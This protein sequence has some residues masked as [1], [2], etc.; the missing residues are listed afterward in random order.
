[1]AFSSGQRSYLLIFCG[2][3]DAVARFHS[4]RSSSSH[5][6]QIIGTTVSNLLLVRNAL[7]DHQHRW[8][9]STSTNEREVSRLEYPSG[10]RTLTRPKT[11][12]TIVQCC[13]FSMCTFPHRLQS[14][15]TYFITDQPFHIC[16]QASQCSHFNTETS[17]VA[18]KIS[19]TRQ[20][21]SML[22]GA[23]WSDDDLAE[24]GRSLTA[25]VLEGAVEDA[26][27]YRASFVD[28]A[29]TTSY[30]KRSVRSEK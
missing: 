4:S 2:L 3:D 10:S 28:P 26:E 12:G 9:Q 5:I 21:V 20:S 13:M 14:S 17:T 22:R 29:R 7:N 30:N 1:M 8:C 16:V 6:V 11:C 23:K 18:V 24:L 25:N 19:E 27:E 15:N